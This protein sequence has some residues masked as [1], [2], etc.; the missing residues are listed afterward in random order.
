MKKLL[1]KSFS[2]GILAQLFKRPRKDDR[3]E[4]LEELKKEISTPAYSEKL[5]FLIKQ[6]LLLKYQSKAVEAA[7]ED[8]HLQLF[9]EKPPQLQIVREE[10]NEEMTTTEQPPT[11]V[12]NLDEI[13]SDEKQQ[14]VMKVENRIPRWFRKPNQYNSQILIA[15]MEL[16]GDNKSVPKYKLEAACKNIKT[17]QSNYSQMKIVGE[18]NHGKVFEEAGN[19]ITLWEPVRHFVKKEY[20]NYQ[21]K[22]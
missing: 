13:L 15:Y 14:E 22:S 9:A 11:R 16:L 12:V 8:L 5:R 3:S 7:L 10:E 21:R 19:R 2:L 18:K 6:D 4:S 17:F 20:E 1:K